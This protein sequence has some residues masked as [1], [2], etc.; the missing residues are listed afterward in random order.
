MLIMTHLALDLGYVNDEEETD[1]GPNDL[2]LPEGILNSRAKRTTRIIEK[3]SREAK[4]I[5]KI[6]DIDI[7]RKKFILYHAK[8]WEFSAIPFTDKKY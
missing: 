8:V 2:E 6:Q 4:E 1:S 3:I 5:L 7:I